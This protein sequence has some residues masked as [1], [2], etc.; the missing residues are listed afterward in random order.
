M[1]TDLGKR[2]RIAADQ[3]YPGASRTRRETS[4]ALRPTTGPR[5]SRQASRSCRTSLSPRIDTISTASPFRSVPRPLA[6]FATELSFGAGTFYSGHIRAGRAL[7]EWRASK[8]FFASV[9]YLQ[10]SVRLHEGNFS[11]RLGRVNF[12]VVFTPDLSW[13]TFIQFDNLS[14]SLGWNSRLR[15]IL[16]PGEEVVFVWNQAFDTA[17]YDLRSTQTNLIGKVSWTFRF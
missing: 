16:R 2:S 3:L 4:S 6:T 17:N 11:T 13:E 9:E 12:N 7:L 15:W 10:N 8:H 14:N 5:S 1:N